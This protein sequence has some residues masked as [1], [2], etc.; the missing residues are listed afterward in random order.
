[1]I[2]DINK[3][4][5]DGDKPVKE[6]AQ[7][8]DDMANVKFIMAER[9]I[10]E[11]LMTVAT[12]SK[13]QR[14]VADAAKGFDFR[15]ALAGARIK[16]GRRFTLLP[17]VGRRDLIAFAINLLYAFDI[18][19]VALQDFLDEYYWSSNG[20]NFSFSLLAHS[21]V[22]PLKNAVLEELN[23]AAD[24]APT[25][26]PVKAAEP[27]P[28]PKPAAPKADLPDEAAAD[29]IERIADICDA[30][31]A[32]N[33]SPGEKRDLYTVAT[34]LVDSVKK[35]DA[36]LI[37]TMMAGFSGVIRAGDFPETLLEKCAELDETLT[38]YNI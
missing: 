16:T 12:S 19:A 13:L 14:V 21:L 1:M 33:P 17:P 4:I 9:R 2:S 31:A 10:S 25:S 38:H 32:E 5:D 3:Y 28:E 30:A 29:I 26:E 22:L 11:L 15:A 36:A 7:I 24:T 35:R 8:C 37:R 20:V 18:R 6:F 27:V 23:G 34:G